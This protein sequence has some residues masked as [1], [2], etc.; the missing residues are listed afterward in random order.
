MAIRWSDLEGVYLDAN[1]TFGTMAWIHEQTSQVRIRFPGDDG[2]DPPPED[3]AGWHLLPDAMKLDL[4]QRLIEDFV[5]AKCPELKDAVRRCF[6]HRGAWR[7]FKD[8]LADR[9]L[10]DRWYR[11]E[12]QARRRALLAW[13]AEEGIEVIEVPAEAGGA[14][15]GG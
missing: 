2:D 13:A 14:E 5:S 11:F 3:E 15:T 6:S 10:L 4:K 9:G 1:M 7:A 12:D 8:L